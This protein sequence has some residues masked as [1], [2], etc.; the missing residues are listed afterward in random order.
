MNIILDHFPNL[1]DDQKNKFLELEKIY[2][3]WNSKINVIS[4][5]DIDNI[6]LHHILHSLSIAKFI[7]FKEGTSILDLGTGGG[8]PGIPLAILYPHVNF[9]LIDGT[10]K[11]ITVVKEI[12]EAVVRKMS[13]SADIIYGDTDYGWQGDIPK[14]KYNSTKARSYGWE[15]KLNSREAVYRAIDEIYNDVTDI[16][17]I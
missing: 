4:R 16:N 6:F 15:P 5:K 12:A 11:K 8:F 14:F 10:R 2:K 9:T 3:F 7:Y 1:S 17:N 13:K